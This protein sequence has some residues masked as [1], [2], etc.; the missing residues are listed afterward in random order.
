LPAFRHVPGVRDFVPP[1]LSDISN[2]ALA[3]LT[4]CYRSPH[5]LQVGACS[6]QISIFFSLHTVLLFYQCLQRYAT[7]AIHQSLVYSDRHLYSMYFRRIGGRSAAHTNVR[8]KQSPA[9]HAF[10]CSA[11]VTPLPWQPQSKKENC[12]A[13]SS[14]FRIGVL[15][16]CYIHPHAYTSFVMAQSPPSRRRPYQTSRRHPRTYILASSNSSPGDTH[17]RIFSH[18][19]TSSL[20]IAFTLALLTSTVTLHQHRIPIPL[21]ALPNLRFFLDSLPPF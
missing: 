11:H 21:L 9:S 10:N 17:L 15:S 13:N 1:W 4:S 8:P 14:F 6:S 2:L 19:S 3:E 7:C 18:L 5:L 20:T 16:I 12:Q